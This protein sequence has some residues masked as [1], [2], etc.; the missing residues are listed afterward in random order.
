MQ[1]S[2]GCCIYRYLGKCSTDNAHQSGVAPIDH[3][4]QQPFARS[5]NIAFLKVD[6]ILQSTRSDMHRHTILDSWRRVCSNLIAT[7]TPDSRSCLFRVCSSTVR[8]ALV[9]N[10][11]RDVIEKPGDL[12]DPIPFFPCTLDIEASRY[13]YHGQLYLDGG[14][15]LPN[16]NPWPGLE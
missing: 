13:Q 9:S 10:A 3:D 1:P 6:F 4:A 8:K 15:M 14:K 7:I 12:L 2:P 16:A 5:V 11:V